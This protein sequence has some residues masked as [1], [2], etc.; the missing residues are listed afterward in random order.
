[1]NDSGKKFKKCCG[2]QKKREYAVLTNQES[3]SRVASAL[4]SLVLSAG[5][6]KSPSNELNGEL[7]GEQYA[8]ATPA[9]NSLKSRVSAG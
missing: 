6:K 2:K 8:S 4:N 7:R 1:M 5:N 9:E 3:A